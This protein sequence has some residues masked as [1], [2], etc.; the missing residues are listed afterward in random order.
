MKEL[1]AYQQVCKVFG[2]KPAKV[3]LTMPDVDDATLVIVPNKV[4]EWEKI[5]KLAEAFGEDQPYATYTYGEIYEKYSAEKLS[6]KL[7]GQKAYRYLYIPANL[8]ESETVSNLAKKYK[9]K[10]IPS[11]LEAICFWYSL[12]ATGKNLNFTTTYIRHIDLKLQTVGG[13]PVVPGSYVSAG[14]KPYLDRS[15]A[16]RVNGARLAVGTNLEPLPL[17]ESFPLPDE[18]TINGKVYRSE[19]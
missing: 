11:V 14:G 9:N 10:R 17:S 2:I 15:D 3:K 1:E 4:F 6:G 8:T 18:L 19:V 5:K 12:R 7:D 16:G 13:W